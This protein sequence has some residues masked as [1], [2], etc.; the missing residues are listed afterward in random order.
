MCMNFM[1]CSMAITVCTSLLIS[2]Y[3]SG[4]AGGTKASVNIVKL[5]ESYQVPYPPFR[6]DAYA[7]NAEVGAI[8]PTSGLLS[9]KTALAAAFVK[10]SALYAGVKQY[11]VP[12]YTKGFPKDL[13]QSYG[14][15]VRANGLEALL[16]ILYTLVSLVF[17]ICK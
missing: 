9:N 3:R 2:S 11:L 8:I 13:Q 4:I 10:Y 14:S 1:A 7:I 12:G 16:P 17:W 6:S 5:L 15:W